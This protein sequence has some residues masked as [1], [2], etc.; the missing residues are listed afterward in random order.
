MMPDFFRRNAGLHGQSRRSDKWLLLLF[1]LL[2]AFGFSLLDAGRLDTART[3]QTE[4]CRQLTAALGLT[5]L[6]L[7]T[8]ARYTRHPS[9][10]DGHAAFQDHPLAFDHFPTGSI[11]SA[12]EWPDRMRQAG[13]GA[14][15]Q[16]S[17]HD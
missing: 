17:R 9:Q 13:Y 7:M 2:L 11:M 10:A 3:A 12:P 14:A 8:E 6:A 1:L 16:G 4:Q 15:S 5:D